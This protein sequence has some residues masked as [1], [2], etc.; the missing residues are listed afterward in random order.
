MTMTTSVGNFVGKWW[1]HWVDGAKD[2]LQKGWRIDIGTGGPAGDSV[3]E[4]TETYNVCV[5]F[6]VIDA[7][8]QTVK[9]STEDHE[10]EQPLSFM[11]VGN[12][13][14]W[15]GYYGQQPLWIYISLSE[16]TLEGKSYY[17]VY[18]STTWGDPDQVGIWGGNGTP[19]PPPDPRP[20]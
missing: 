3:P 20:V 4:L 8:N 1:V 9:L 19:P 14:Q 18:G 5:G 17:S 11:L 13:L 7:E 6:A 15:K 12:Q 10:G 16:T 2:W